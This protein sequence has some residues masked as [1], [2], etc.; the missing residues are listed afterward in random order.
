MGSCPSR[1][2]KKMQWATTEQAASG[3]SPAFANATAAR[4]PQAPPTSVAVAGAK[5]LP[6]AARAP[7]ARARQKAR[8]CLQRSSVGPPARASRAAPAGEWRTL[9]PAASCRV[10]GRAPK[11]AG[12]PGPEMRQRRTVYVRAM[13]ATLNG[14]RR[15][16]EAAA[17]AAS[18]HQRTKSND[19]NMGRWSLPCSAFG[20]G[21]AGV[22]F[23]LRRPTL[24]SVLC[25]S[26]SIHVHRF[27]LYDEH[28][29]W[30]CTRLPHWCSEA[31][32]SSSRSGPHL[33]R[34]NPPS[35]R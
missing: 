24:K 11:A 9:R 4:S 17:R 18:Q 14:G 26:I 35:T 7:Q 15:I 28:T 10:P 23:T 25:Q 33:K 13:T 32:A 1:R 20:M 21:S 30:A 8:R 27:E 5:G 6:C 2:L 22:V 12:P 19:A 3:A 16:D 34:R 31:N 29:P